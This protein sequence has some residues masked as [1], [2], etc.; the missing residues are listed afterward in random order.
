V[1]TFVSL[2]F[3]IAFEYSPFCA[4]IVPS[5]LV[6]SL[7]DDV[8]AWLPPNMTIPQSLLTCPHDQSLSVPPAS[9]IARCDRDP[10]AFTDATAN[11]AWILCE[12]SQDSCKTLYDWLYAPGNL[13][14]IVLGPE[15]TEILYTTLYRARIVLRSGDQAMIDAFRWCNALTSYQLLPPALLALALVSAVPVVLAIAV[16]FV[17]AFVR[18][19]LSSYAMT[20]A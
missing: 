6:Q 16:R 10:Y 7:V 11:A 20:H 18:V 2:T 3:F 19:Q 13:V 5:C 12:A 9:C 8:H 1:I 15:P 4:P 17:V 14:E